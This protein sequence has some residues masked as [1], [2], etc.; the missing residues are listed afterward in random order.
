MTQPTY[1]FLFDM[2]GVICDN[3]AYH[4]SSW[5][6]YARRLGKELTDEDVQTKVYGKTNEEIL[7]YVLGRPVTPEEV[8]YHAETKEALFREMYRPHFELTPGLEAFLADAKAQGVRL[9]LATNAPKSNLDFSWEIGDLGRFYETAAHPGLVDRPKPA[10]DL[11]L[12]V[13]AQLGVEPHR[14][15]VFEDSLTG[16]AAGLAAGSQVVGIAS[17]YPFDRLEQVAQRVT[18]DF[19]GITV[20]ECLALIDRH[21]KLAV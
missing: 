3:N 13:A 21:P 14:C 10:P 19:T 15:L 11:Y 16:I 20:A 7:L 6:E 2:D 18:K 4:K 5:L 12:Y 8:D 17:T 9:G 1:A